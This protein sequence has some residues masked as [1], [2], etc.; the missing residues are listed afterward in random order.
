ML[1]KNLINLHEDLKNLIGEPSDVEKIKN[2]IK[3]IPSIKTYFK[4]KS[5]TIEKTKNNNIKIL[6]RE[7]KRAIYLMKIDNKIDY[8]ITEYKEDI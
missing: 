6:N 8:F 5:Y 3:N 2:F 7:I 1:N 4:N